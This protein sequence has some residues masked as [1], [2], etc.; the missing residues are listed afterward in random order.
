MDGAESRGY[1]RAMSFRRSTL[2]LIATSTTCLVAWASGCG[3]NSAT[4]T[5][6]GF[7]T[8]GAS[9]GTTST[10]TSTASANGGATTG[11]L[12]SG[13]TSAGNPFGDGGFSTGVSGAGGT[14]TCTGLGCQIHT[15]PNN[16]STTISGTVYDPAG[17]NPLYGIVAYVP[18][19]KPGP[20]VSGTSCQSC[21]DLYTGDPLAAAVTDATGKFTIKNAPD[22]ASIPLV[23]QVGKWRKQ[24]VV[25]TVTMCADTAVPDKTLTLPKNS[26]EG[27]LPNIAIST[28][29]ADTLECLLTRI[30]VDPAE[31]VPGASASGHIHIFQG[32][33]GPNTNPAAPASSA[34]LWDSDTDIAKYD[35][36]MLSCEG[37]ETS[38]MNQQ[39]MMDY[40]NSCGRVF[41]SHFHYA[42][43]DTGPFAAYNLATWTKG[44]NQIGNSL[45]ANVVTTF[46]VGM[47]FQ[48]WLENVGALTNGELTIDQP[49]HNADVTAAN[50]LSQAWLTADA[51]SQAPNAA[52]DFSF[53]TPLDAMDA[54]E[55]DGR[56]VFSDMHVGA[57]PNGVT[58]PDGCAV[59]NLTAQ[60][61]ALEFILFNLS[62]C[63]TPG[64]MAQMPPPVGSGPQ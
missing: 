46:Q 21:N 57:V 54:G 37:S 33:G 2:A 3:G 8:G 47:I 64:G 58:T 13:S 16:G 24:L 41:A 5:T 14:T 49:R 61:D 50:T 1:S 27:D 52:Q 42:W 18:G 19:S 40:T 35:I 20:L 30:G 32:R 22:G 38:N 23:I 25:P 29:G 53:D 39:V 15:C 6:S 12:S 59:R 56:V 63:V 7:N 48:Q 60:E 34:A 51:K 62:S 44:S 10:G 43:F 4:H 36:T 31:Y 17:K 45:N 26:S 28:G 9:T 55:K 11:S